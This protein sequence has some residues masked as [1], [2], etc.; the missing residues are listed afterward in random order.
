MK[1]KFSQKPVHHAKNLP[2]MHLQLHQKEQV[3]KRLVIWL[4]TKLLIKLQ[5][6]QNSQQNKSEI[7]TNEYD[8]EIPKER[9]IFPEERPD[10]L[11]NI[12]V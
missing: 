9:H 6:V 10:Y 4:A 12:I 1:G 2:Q 7:V 11:I 5:G 8:K 3:K